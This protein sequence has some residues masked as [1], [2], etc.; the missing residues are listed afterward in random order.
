[1]RFSTLLGLLFVLKGDKG[2]KLRS[3]PKKAGIHS[4]SPR[5]RLDY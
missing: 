2:S 1:M 3:V 4:M 5:R